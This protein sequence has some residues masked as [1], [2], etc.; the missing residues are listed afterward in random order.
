[1]HCIQYQGLYL[2]PGET[3]TRLFQRTRIP[4]AAGR[5][6]LRLGYEATLLTDT[7]LWMTPEPVKEV[8]VVAGESTILPVTATDSS[9]QDARYDLNGRRLPPHS[10]HKG[11]CLRRKDGLYKK[12]ISQ[13]E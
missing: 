7:I 5:Y 8:E 3:T 12:T 4:L 9:V 2:E 11:V 10:H 13:T 6:S 1:M